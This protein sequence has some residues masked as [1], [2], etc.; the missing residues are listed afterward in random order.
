MAGSSKRA[1]AASS[2]PEPA[3]AEGGAEGPVL[4]LLS[5]RLRAV[6]KKLKNVETLEALQRESKELN[7]E[8]AR[9]SAFRAGAFAPKSPYPR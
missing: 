1:P 5:K 6:R 8:Q 3:P 7:P 2:D 4:A 9:R